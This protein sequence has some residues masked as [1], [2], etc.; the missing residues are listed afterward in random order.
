MIMEM[1]FTAAKRGTCNRLKVGAIISKDFRP[2]SLGYNGAPPGMRHCGGEC[3][4]SNPCLNT[5]HAERNAID[6]A[7]RNATEYGIENLGSLTMHVTHSP[8]EKCAELILSSNI[9]RLV[10]CHRY[11]DDSPIIKLSKIIEVVHCQI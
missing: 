3:N 9:S 5:L 7:E 6:W 10:F 8:C 2:I 11:R 4:E 1:A